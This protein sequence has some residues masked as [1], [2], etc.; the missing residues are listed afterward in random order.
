VFHPL[1]R[2]QIRTIVEIHTRGLAEAVGGA[3]HHAACDKSGAGCDRQRRLRPE[4]WS[5]SLKRVIQQRIQNPLATE[6]LKGHVAEGRK[7]TID[8]QHGEFVFNTADE[9]ETV[10]ETEAV[11]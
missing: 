2:A 9:S 1:S 5:T 8:A 11:S 7:L 6:I 10:I 4:L 3:R